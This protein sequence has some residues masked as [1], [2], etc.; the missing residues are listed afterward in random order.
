MEQQRREMDVDCRIESRRTKR[1]LWLARKSFCGQ[2]SGCPVRIGWL[3]RL[4][5]KRLSLRRTGIRFGGNGGIA[6][7]SLEIQWERMDMDGRRDCCKS[8]G[9][10]RHIA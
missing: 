9:H 1:H 4:F 5:R 8:E 2:Y 10:I 7:R 6:Q 3:D